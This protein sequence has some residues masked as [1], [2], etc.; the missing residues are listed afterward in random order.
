MGHVSKNGDLYQIDGDYVADV[1]V[2][3][4]PVIT[5]KQAVEAAV[6][7]YGK[8]PKF[9]VSK[10]ELAILAEAS[11]QNLVWQYDASFETIKNGPSKI[12]YVIDAKSGKTIRSYD[13]IMH[14]DIPVDISGN[15]LSG[16]GG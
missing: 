11:G 12:R 5:S 15:L 16:E 8:Q 1:T 7:A 2:G 3:T 10:P 4:T 6:S 14:A 9:K 13:T